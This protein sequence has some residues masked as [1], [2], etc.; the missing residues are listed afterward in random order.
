[1]SPSPL[2]IDLVAAAAG[3]LRVAHANI[4][5]GIRVVS[6]ERGHDPRLCTLVAFGGAGPMHGTPVARE[7]RI[8]RVAIPPAPGILCALGQLLSDLRHDLIE[9]HI[10]P[11]RSEMQARAAAVARRLADAADRLLAAD[12]VP[13]EKRAVEV[14]VEARYVGQSYELPI[15]FDHRDAGAW[16]RVVEDFHTA[17]R[18]R[19]GHADPEAPIEI[20]GFGATAIGKVD[21]PEL[22]MLAVGRV[23]STDGRRTGTPGVLRGARSRRC[24][25]LGHSPGARAR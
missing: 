25:R 11:Y 20:V 22:P 19:F 12:R 18:N 7:L 4:V 10:F 6:V 2:G 1:M 15:A 13:A 14:R 3:I 5:R 17:H 23:Q 21:A 9:T 24:R 16:S 8:G